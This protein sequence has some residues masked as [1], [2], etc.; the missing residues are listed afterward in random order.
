MKR[1]LEEDDIQITNTNTMKRILEEDDIQI[2]T[3]NDSD[4]RNVMIHSLC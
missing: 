1:I 2:T 4:N 3:D